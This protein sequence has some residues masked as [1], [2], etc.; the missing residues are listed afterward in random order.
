MTKK[1]SITPDTTTEERIKEAARV[2]FMKKGYA[3]TRTRDIAEEA[4][5]NLALLNYYFRSKEKLFDIIMMEK[6]Q[7]LFG[8]IAPVLM[9]PES[10]FEEKITLI[11]ESYIDMLR[12]NPDLPIFVLS[13]IRNNPQQ[14]GN[15]IQAGNLLT[16]SY[17]IKQLQ[18]RSPK[19]NPMH[20]L[21]NILGMTIFPFIAKPV[22][23][24]AGVM[25]V[26]QYD[27]FLEERK[28]LIPLWV[29]AMIESS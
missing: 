19:I 6:V 12:K 23:Q 5:I 20:F 2:V 25:K 27:A 15:I 16:N 1:T 26:K 8:V 4:G 18:Q 11:V 10:S 13:E 7:K 17:F 9:D 14:F 24:A 28:K 21:L 22:F 29:K 3:A